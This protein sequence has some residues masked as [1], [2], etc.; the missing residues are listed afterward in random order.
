VSTEVLNNATSGSPFDPGPWVFPV[1]DLG[2]RRP[3]VS[4]GWG[5]PRHSAEGS[6][7][8]HL[9]ADIMFRRRSK[10]DL[11][12]EFKPG[13]ANASKGYFVPDNV[14]ALAAATGVV[15]FAAWTRRGFTVRI[16]HTNGW[17]TYY[18]HL[19]L[20]SVARGQVVKAGQ[21]IGIVG[22]DPT[23]RR[24]LM[25]LHFELWRGRQRSGAT[26]PAPYLAA[27]ERRATTGSVPVHRNGGLTYR[28]VGRRGERYPAWLRALRGA[29][30]VYVIRERNAEGEPEVVY[31]GQSN[32]G[33]LYETLTRHF[34]TWRRWKG[35]WRGQF[36][37]GHDPGLTYK[38]ER[39]EVAVRTTSSA[40]ALDEEARLIA[41][42]RPRDNLIGQP[43]EVPF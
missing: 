21:T 15:D 43:E 39:A 2:D 5:S 22:Y 41:R 34:Q 14:P 11:V 28:P 18:T 8:L 12:D 13:T 30:G 26:N 37:E 1:P 33:R 29:S 16:L 19:S 6:R 7:T 24:K 42:L 4:D 9:G 38:R 36:S 40:N 27:W 17:M 23:D 31:V 20:L 3:E 25:H 10:H 35:F 32:A